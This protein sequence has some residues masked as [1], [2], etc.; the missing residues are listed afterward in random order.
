MNFLF[1]L[2]HLNKPSNFLLSKL[3]KDASW[4]FNAQVVTSVVSL[5]QVVIL[6]RILGVKN[7]GILGLIIIYVEIVNQLVDFRVWETATKYISQYW[8]KEERERALATVKLCYLTD[9]STG[10][11]SFIIVVLSAAMASNYILHEPEIGSLIKIFA[12]SLLLKTTDNTSIAILRVFDKFRWLSFYEIFIAIMRFA[13]IILFLFLG[14]GLKGVIFGYICA[15]GLGGIMA[16][17][18]ALL[19]IKRRFKKTWWLVRTNLIKDKWKEMAWFL[20]NTNLHAFLRLFSSKSDVILLGYYTNPIAVGYYKLARDIF[21]AV[22]R[23]G[24]PINK[25]IYP[26]IAK[27]IAAGEETQVKGL[28]KKIS[29]LIG[30]FVVFAG[31]FVSLFGEK[32]VVIVAGADFRPAG[33]A[34]SIIIWSITWLIFIWIPSVLLSFNKSGLL[35]I[36]N[37][38]STVSLIAGL[39]I[40][41]PL[42]GFI[43]TSVVVLLYYILWTIL[44][45]MCY[46]LFI[47]KAH[48]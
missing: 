40:V 31:I 45:L 24:E 23:I 41:I 11:L 26:L 32:I 38:L 35:T 13:F 8:I 2:L 15:S 10:I 9:F 14:F 34:L 5:I 4:L 29:F 3:I 12:I 39:F 25:A 43:G 21:L 48:E 33:K 30:I 6:A 36:I 46:F 18:S 19:E 17:T 44:S 1:K 7:F 37:L 47:S 20:A 42:Y 22:S 16:G 28:I 27:L